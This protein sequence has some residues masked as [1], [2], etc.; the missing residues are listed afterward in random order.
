MQ[1]TFGTVLQRAVTAGLVT[2]LLMGLYLYLVVEPTVS[3]AIVLEESLAAAD[4]TE[5]Q[6]FTRGE[7]TAGGVAA[8]VTYAVIMAVIFGVVLARCRHHLPGRSDLARS[9][10]LAGAGFTVFALIPALKYPANPPAVGDPDTVDERTLQYLACLAVSLVAAIAL[11]QLAERLRHRTDPTTR[12]AA[13]T[14]AAVAL[15]G[16]ILVV[17]PASPD[18]IAPQVPASLVWDF[19]IRSIGN[20]ALLWTGLGMGTGLLLQ[21]AGPSIAPRD[22]PERSLR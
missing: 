13:V 9:L 19:R 22:E 3:E 4:P 16:V 14:A 17:L 12:T 20:L 1:I 11:F 5:E 21:R 7:Q 10:W 2:G 15:Y 18:E 6:R 8:N